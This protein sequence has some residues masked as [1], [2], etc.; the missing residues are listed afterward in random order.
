MI[1]THT[2]TDF[3]PYFL[4]FGNLYVLQLLVNY[5]FRIKQ[6]QNIYLDEISERLR[7]LV[8]R[9]EVSEIDDATGWIDH[10]VVLHSKSNALV[11]GLHRQSSGVV[12]CVGWEVDTGLD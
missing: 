5:L 10:K 3:G 4:T 7:R 9:T 8:E 6:K 2:H 12:V 11:F 1:H